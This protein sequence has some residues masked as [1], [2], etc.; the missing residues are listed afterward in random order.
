MRGPKS[1][2]DNPVGAGESSYS[3]VIFTTHWK[4]LYVNTL[5]LRDIDNNNQL[6]IISEQTNII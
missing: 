5:G 3:L 4:P 2:I 1:Y 6:I